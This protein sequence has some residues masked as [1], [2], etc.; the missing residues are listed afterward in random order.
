M[1]VIP[2]ADAYVVRDNKTDVIR[3]LREIAEKL[4]IW[5]FDDQIKLNTRKCHFL[6]NT[7]DKNFLKI[8]NFN[9]KNFFTEKLLGIVFDCNLK[10]SKETENICKSNKEIDCPFQESPLH[11]HF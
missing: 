4:L 1:Y 9:I 10:F 6:L 2:T 3:A 8:A 11:G 5:F 7:E